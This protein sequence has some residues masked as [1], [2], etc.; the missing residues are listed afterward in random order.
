MMPWYR[1]L[2][3][4]T[5]LK[6]FRFGC[7]A[8][9]C[10]LLLLTDVTPITAPAAYENARKLFL[11]GDLSNSQYEAES[12]YR[13]FVI[14]NPA[15]ASKFQ[16][17]DAE[18]MSKRGLYEDVLRLLS[19]RQAAPNDPEGNIRKLTLEG[20][21][22]IELDRTSEGDERLANAGNLCARWP[23]PSCGGVLRARGFFA[24]ERG[25][26]AVG[27][28]FLL[29][30]LQFGH[31]HNDRLLEATSLL[32]L[33]I[34]ALH[35]EHYDEALDWSRTAY[36]AFIDIGSEDQAER[37]LGNQ[38]WAYYGLGDSEK[39]LELFAD[40]EKRAELLGDTAA[41]VLWV[42]TTGDVYA[43]TDQLQLAE[44]SYR[45][46]LK[47]AEQINDREDTA[48][49]SMDLAQVYVESGKLEEADHY[50]NQAWS[51]AQQSGNRVDMLNS[52][53]ILGQTAARRHDW[54]RAASLL[55]EVDNA[56]ESQTSMKWAAEH[57]L[58]QLYEAQSQTPAAQHAYQSALATF[59]RA[60]ADLKQ[61]D[62]RL[63]FVSNATRIYDD[64]IQFLIS[65]KKSVP[66]LEAADWSRARTLEQ[67][68]GLIQNSGPVQPLPFSPTQIA[69]KANATIL[70]YWLGEKQSYL[71]AV[72]PE[73]TLLIP[74]PAKQ[75]ISAKIAQ[76]NK[77]ML[78]LEDPIKEQNEDGAALFNI[79]VAPA[80]SVISPRRPVIVISDGELSQLNFE[81]LLV[82]SPTPHYW[83][84][85][86]TIFSAPSIR[87]VTAARPASKG[88]GRLLLIG[89]AVSPDPDYPDLP[90]AYSEI[91]Q[92]Q[93]HFSPS[94]EDVYT[95]DRATP[96]AYLTSKPEQFSYIHFVTHGTASR[97]SPLDSAVILSSTR[98]TQ[99]GYKLYARDILAHPIN[100]RLV[101]MAACYSSG[102]R[103][104]AG[105]GLVGLSWAFLRAGA[106]ST[107]ASLWDVSDES[108]P[109]LMDNLYTGLGNGR[110]P[111]AS[112]RAA[113]LSLLHSNR[114]FHKPF[115]WA[116]F[117][118]YVGR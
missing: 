42:I 115:Y 95:R 9:S 110:T 94:G 17:L 28:K 81:T 114:E 64:Y 3:R 85:D 79:L 33:G 75:Q 101:T 105:E 30:S 107:I 45:Q 24:I 18:V 5:R 19:A 109:L 103:S 77:A 108:T 87:M 31:I 13:R 50:A 76:Y 106:H 93:K 56:P 44:Q 84:E 65:Q 117:Q 66:A 62:S 22:L 112:L 32:N 52:H 67:G 88:S 104:Y 14:S 82:S 20:I 113:K 11:K 40:A 15:W 96:T 36:R 100:A 12:G 80:S 98:Q 25:Q 89:D 74:L 26:S 55:Q 111:A 41:R 61:D 51:M 60:R 99:N 86:A 23:Y 59:E 72:S 97:L 63:S 46:A 54:S 35:E 53:L 6:S 2:L 43:G 49:A 47:Y 116:P 118:L 16:M 39:A 10:V 69:R 1:H 4:V 78:R 91:Q 71:W 68:L 34:A 21:A 102:T 37:A 92:I 57:E 8:L 7:A 48:N 38:G 27:R 90:M 29:Q 83:I 73:K 70:F 58:A